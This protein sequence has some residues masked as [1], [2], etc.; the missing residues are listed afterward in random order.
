MPV[1]TLIASICFFLISIVTVAQ[2]S[3]MDSPPSP[4]P[5]IPP[6]PGFPID[7]YVY[8]VFFIALIMGVRK[9][10]QKIKV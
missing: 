6:P 9:K 10:L 1:K 4:P 8:V 2:G 5:P 3:G 7:S